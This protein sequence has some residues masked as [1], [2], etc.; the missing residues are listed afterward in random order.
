MWAHHARGLRAEVAEREKNMPHV[1]ERTDSLKTSRKDRRWFF[2][3]VP[4]DWDAWQDFFGKY[5]RDTSM[6]QQGIA[7][8]ATPGICPGRRQPGGMVNE[9]FLEEVRKI[10]LLGEAVCEKPFDS[11]S[12]AAID[13]LNRVLSVNNRNLS[14]G[15]ALLIHDPIQGEQLIHNMSHSRFVRH[16][17]RLLLSVAASSHALDWANQRIL[18]GDL[19]SV[20]A[21]QSRVVRES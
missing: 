15:Y 16:W 6:V 5:T 3:G 10:P 11:Q 12:P 13:H 4:C 19:V 9:R 2:C 21:N 1:P 17:E 14:M 7:F 18:C 8:Q 20:I